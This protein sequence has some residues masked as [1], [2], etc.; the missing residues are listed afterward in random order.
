MYQNGLG[1]KS[2]LFPQLS[3]RDF[4]SASENQGLGAEAALSIRSADPQQLFRVRSILIVLIV[5]TVRE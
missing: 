3:V 1:I 2:Y 5:Q 4:G